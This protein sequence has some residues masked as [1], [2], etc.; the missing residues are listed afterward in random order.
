MP[1]LAKPGSY[2]AGCNEALLRAVPSS[3][4]RILEVGCAEGK[5]GAAL[6]HP[7]AKEHRK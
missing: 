7:C 6:K 2:Y 1:A 3:A 5:L 4:L